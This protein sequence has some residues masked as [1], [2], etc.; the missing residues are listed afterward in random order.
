MKWC[1]CIGLAK[2][3]LRLCFVGLFQPLSESFTGNQE[4]VIRRRDQTD[5]SVIEKTEAH[6]LEDGV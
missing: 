5:R 4:L 2:C 1:T 3:D 6:G